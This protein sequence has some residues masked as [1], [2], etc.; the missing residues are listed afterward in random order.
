[1][2]GWVHRESAHHLTVVITAGS[3]S[4]MTSRRATFF[5]AALMAR[6]MDAGATVG[7]VLLALDGGAAF[8]GV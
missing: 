5:G 3:R 6:S 2:N 8:A 1:M 7:M 4:T